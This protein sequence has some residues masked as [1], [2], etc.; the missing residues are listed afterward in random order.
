M[1]RIMLT[2][3]DYKSLPIFLLSNAQ[4]YLGNVKQI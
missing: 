1:I 2:I 4:H 3:P